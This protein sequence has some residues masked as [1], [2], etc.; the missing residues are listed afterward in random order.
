MILNYF[1]SLCES[2]K[3][4]RLA[5]TIFFFVSGFGYSSWASRI[6]AIK[7]QLNLSEAEFGAVL[8]AFPIGLMLTMPFTG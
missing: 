4:Y 7:E 1:N 6:P 5:T 3:G 8:F 2:P